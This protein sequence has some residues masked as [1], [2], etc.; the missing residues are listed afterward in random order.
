ME[1][2]ARSIVSR[3]AALLGLAATAASS[4]F[5]EAA[6]ADATAENRAGPVFS[7]SGP[8][9]ALRDY[10]RLG[11]LLAHDGAWE[12]EQVIPVQWLIEVTTL[13]AAEAYLRAGQNHAEVR[14]WLFPAAPSRSAAPIRAGRR[15]RPARLRRPVLE[16]GHGP[17]GR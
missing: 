14:L 15:Q 4:A 13:R 7:A 8:N 6:P 2:R 17:D 10:A 1:S 16:T 3:R 11:R 5:A 9:A 12:G